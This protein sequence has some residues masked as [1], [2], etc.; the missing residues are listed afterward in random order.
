MK[1]NGFWKQKDSLK[2][3]DL[4]K[5]NDQNNWKK[6]LINEGQSVFHKE[7][8]FLKVSYIENP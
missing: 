2:E 6:L 1:K 7:G 4:L 8:P 5:I 3:I